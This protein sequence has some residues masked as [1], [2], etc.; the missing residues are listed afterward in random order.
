M[1]RSLND[2]SASA[3]A[4]RDADAGIELKSIPTSRHVTSRHVTS[5]HVTSAGL[6]KA[7]PNVK[8]VS[9]PDLL[10]KPMRAGGYYPL[11]TYNY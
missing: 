8:I 6:Y 7:I 10:P 11:F 1:R 5:P 3:Y 2:V 4:I 9:R